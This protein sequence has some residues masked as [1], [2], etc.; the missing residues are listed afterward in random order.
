M[1]KISVIIP[2]RNRSHLLER[3]LQSVLNQTMKDYEVIVI[4]DGSTDETARYLSSLK[5]PF[6]TC[7]HLN[8]NR[9]G[10]A[11]RNTGISHASGEFVAFL[12]DDD[13]WEATKLKEQVTL[14][15]SKNAGLCQTGRNVYTVSGIKR[16]YIFYAPRYSDPLKSIMGDN[17]IGTTSSIM[18]RK[19]LV[20]DVGGFDP[21]LP[22]L[23]DWDFYIRLIKKGCLVVGI[24]KPLV[25]YYIIGAQKNVSFDAHRHLAAV[26][27]LKQKFHPEPFF[28][29]FKRALMIITVKKMFKSRCFLQSWISA[30]KN[31]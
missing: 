21:E 25:N 29:L 11:A 26:R 20:N 10:G 30:S 23:Q 7:V 9:G 22:A 8:E 18:V 1:P 4:N 24:D 17:Y 16:K 13:T 19:Q 14:M 6:L 5:L 31:G 28:P 12:D 27:L 2:T 3:A 15:E